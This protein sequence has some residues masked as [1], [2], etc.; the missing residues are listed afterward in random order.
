[1]Y[2]WTALFILYTILVYFNKGDSINRVLAVS[3]SY[4][5]LF[6]IIP[7]YASY[8]IHDYFISRK[9]YLHYFVFIAAV[10]S[11]SGTFSYYYFA[12]LFDS[13]YMYV[14]WLGNAIF[15]VGLG[16]AVKVLKREVKDR[17]QIHE[18]KAQQ[19][20]SELA[21]LK[22]QINPHFFFNTLNNLYALSLMKSEQVP[23]VILKLSEL[24]RYILSSSNENKVDLAQENEFL[25]NYLYLQKFR[26]TQNQNIK[27]NVDGNI[28]GIKIAPM[29]L[30]P[31]V[32][33]SFKHGVRAVTD[34]FYIHINLKVSDD[35]LTFTV[36]N[37][38]PKQVENQSS[39]SIRLGLN[40][41]RRRLELLYPDKHTLEISDKPDRYLVTLGLRL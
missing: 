40:N 25:Q 30:M 29:L 16:I 35:N 38:K 33:N 13:P 34:Q 21:L 24:M 14:Q 15:V 6:A 17:M 22:S 18:I 7:V 10:I 28:A 1:M 8:L 2:T 27:Y 9:M 19:L 39:D 3:L 37:S 4:I 5:V 23:G 31:F 32:E 36:D 26:F 41:V 20:E 11:V 12:L